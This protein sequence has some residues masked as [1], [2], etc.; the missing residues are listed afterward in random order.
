MC[1]RFKLF[2]ERKAYCKDTNFKLNHFT[3]HSTDPEIKRDIAAHRKAQA[4]RV[5]KPW[6][7][8]NCVLSIVMLFLYLQYR[9]FTFLAQSVCGLLASTAL[10]VLTALKKNEYA[11]YVLYAQYLVQGTLVVLV[12]SLLRGSF[13][14]AKGEIIAY[15]FII[16]M[17][18]VHRFHVAFLLMTPSLLCFAYF[19]TKFQVEQISKLK[20][21]LPENFQT[22]VET[23]YGAMVT[24]RSLML[25]IASVVF[26]FCH[27]QYELQATTHII[28]KSITAKQQKQLQQFVADR[29]QAVLLYRLSGPDNELTLEVPLQNPAVSEILGLTF[30]R[31]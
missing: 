31:D 21:F 4:S 3:L 18:P 14:M 23:A 27:Y 5:S 28:D 25:L 9:S 30:K 2:I 26:C 6:I 29:R 19:E 20:Q 24:S 11:K 10:L 8:L 17:L 15:W 16:M 1:G 7:G 13:Q 22:E 12:H